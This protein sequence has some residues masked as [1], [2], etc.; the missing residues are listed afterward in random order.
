MGGRGPGQCWSRE[1]VLDGLAGASINGDVVEVTPDSSWPRVK[2]DPT[3]EY[4][5]SLTIYNSAAPDR[6]VLSVCNPANASTLPATTTRVGFA[7]VVYDV[8]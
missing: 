2:V 4:A 7:Y 3:H 6:F 8:P 5:L 1:P